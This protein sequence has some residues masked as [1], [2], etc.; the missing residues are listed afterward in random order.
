MKI[1]KIEPVFK[2]VEKSSKILFKE[3]LSSE[4]KMKQKYLLIFSTIFLGE[5][6]LLT[7]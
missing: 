4:S 5:V 6:S 1:E 3:I 7:A 2:E